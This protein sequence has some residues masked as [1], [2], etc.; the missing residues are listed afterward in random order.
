MVARIT[1]S[2][3]PVPTPQHDTPMI[4]SEKFPRNTS[5]A[6]AADTTV[7]K[8][9]VRILDS[10]YYADLM[11]QGQS[12]LATAMVGMRL[13]LQA[14]GGTTRAHGQPIPVQRIPVARVGGRH[15]ERAVPS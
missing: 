5:G 7:A 14:Y 10:F 12:D 8:I 15:S 13:V 2:C 4:A 3:A 1:E 6:A 11:G 9:I